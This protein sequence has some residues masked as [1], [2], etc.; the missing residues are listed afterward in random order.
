MTQSMRWAMLWLAA[1]TLLTGCDFSGSGGAQSGGVQRYVFASGGQTGV[2][3]PTAGAIAGLTQQADPAVELTVQTSGGSVA[4]ARMLA[5]GDAD[6]AILQNDIA[7]YARDGL[8]MFEGEANPKLMG[9]AALY[10]EHIQIIALPDAGVKTVADL[11]GKRVAIGAIGSGTEANALQIL[12]AYNLSEDDLVRVERLKASEA[13]DYLQDERVDAAFFTFGVGTAAIQEMALT[14][15]IVF[16]A[17]D[18]EA[19]GSLMDKHPFYRA[20]SIPAGAYR[21]AEGS[22]TAVPPAD[23]PTV[24]VMA[25]LCVRSEVP[26]GAV[27]AVLR[28]MFDHL[29]DLRRTHARLRAVNKADANANLTLPKHAGAEAFY[30]A[31]E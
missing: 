14:R 26:A 3:Y 15:D 25:T 30:N 27:E 20:A 23:V 31:A 17:V 19:R 29:D 2:Y 21:K 5:S 9:V 11:K 18:G 4:N 10:P 7:A 8:L 24:S 12:E 16:V 13:R 22:K 1:A 28:G 6:F